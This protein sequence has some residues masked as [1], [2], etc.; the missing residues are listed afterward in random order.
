MRLLLV[1]AAVSVGLSLGGC[2]GDDEGSRDCVGKDLF[3]PNFDCGGA[4][5]LGVG[6]ACWSGTRASVAGYSVK[7]YSLTW[8]GGLF[9]GPGTYCHPQRGCQPMIADGQP[10]DGLPEDALW[11]MCAEKAHGCYPADPER[12]GLAGGPRVCRPFPAT[13]GAFCD[14]SV[15]PDCEAYPPLGGEIAFLGPTYA[16]G[17]TSAYDNPAWSGEGYTG[18]H[19]VS[20]V[21]IAE[22]HYPVLRPA[23]LVCRAGRCV[24][25]PGRGEP[26][27]ELPPSATYPARGPNRFVCA[28]PPEFRVR[29]AT[30]GAGFGAHY[31]YSHAVYCI[32]GV[33]TPAADLEPDTCFTMQGATPPLDPAWCSTPAETCA[34]RSASCLSPCRGDG[35]CGMCRVCA[36]ESGERVVVEDEAACAPQGGEW[37]ASPTEEAVAALAAELERGPT[38]GFTYAFDLTLGGPVT[39]ELWLEF[40]ARGAF[41]GP[42]AAFDIF[43]NGERLERW[44]PGVACVAP[45]SGFVPLVRVARRL[46]PRVA[47]T[48]VGGRVRVEFRGTDAVCRCNLDD[49]LE[50]AIQNRTRRY[51]GWVR[52]DAL[53]AER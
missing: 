23:P 10:C 44:H 19:L 34:D 36:L 46:D 25:P 15:K 1:A 14:A 53:C 48:A 41:S 7:D 38:C 9:C 51:V 21:G 24:P 45:G 31:D 22:N 13:E 30:T 29:P 40:A 49:T 32:G 39:G 4:D 6:Q 37:S 28:Q 16:W 5:F 12:E 3:G 33:C 18:K 20:G 47:E 17:A 50:V 35:R 27:A 11:G 26:C 43:V 8:G 2:G 42:A 52:D